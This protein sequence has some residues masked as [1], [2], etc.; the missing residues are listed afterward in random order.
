[1]GTGEVMPREIQA[2]TPVDTSTQDP[3]SSTRV[4]PPS[5]QVRQDESQVHGDDHGRGFDQ[6][7]KLKEIPH[8][9]KMMMMDPSNINLKN[10]TQGYIKWF[11]EIIPLTTFLGAFKEG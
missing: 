5:F 2:Q 11:N 8:K 10:L 1:M 4:E 3:S 7:M 6:V 9:L